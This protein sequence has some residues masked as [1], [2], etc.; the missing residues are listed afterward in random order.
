MS[1]KIIQSH[2]GASHYELTIKPI[3]I[4][5]VPTGHYTIEK[6]KK[7]TVYGL[8][9]NTQEKMDFLYNIQTALASWHNAYNFIVTKNK[10]Y[11]FSIHRWTSVENKDKERINFTDILLE[12]ILNFGSLEKYNITKDYIELIVREAANDGKLTNIFIIPAD[13]EAYTFLSWT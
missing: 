10:E 3:C 1:E 2:S 6:K 4:S 7:I 13:S 11:L 12:T 9:D 5:G 8:L